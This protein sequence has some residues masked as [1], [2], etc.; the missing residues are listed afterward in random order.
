MSHVDSDIVYSI[1]ADVDTGHGKMTITWGKIHKCLGMT[2]YYYSPVKLILSMA[3]YI[4]KMLDD[5]PEE[6]NGVPSTAA[7][8]HLFYIAEDATKLSQTDVDIINH[9]VA[10]IFFLSKRARP[11]IQ[12]IV[13]FLCTLL[14]ELDTDDIKNLERVM[15]YIHDTIDLT[16]I[17][18]M[19]NY[20][21]I[22]WYVN[23]LFAVHKDTKIHTGSFMTMGTGG[24]YLKYTKLDTK[25]ST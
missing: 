12:M 13:S 19:D 14:R 22:K 17:L 8:L 15:K 21:N 10:Q 4:E 24:A 6:T 23:A 2:I 3:D 7:T 18:S 9:F 16:L 25:S 11:Y 5:I 1:L 20:G